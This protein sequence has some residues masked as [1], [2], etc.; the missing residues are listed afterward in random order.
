MKDGLAVDTIYKGQT[1]YGKSAWIYIPKRLL[2]EDISKNY[3]LTGFYDYTHLYQLKNN[4]WEDVAAGGY[5]MKYSDESKIADR[6]SFRLFTDKNDIADAYLV[7]CRRFNNYSPSIMEGKLMTAHQIH[8]WE[9]NINAS[10][11]WLNTI[12]TLLMGMMV[13]SIII[14][15]VRFLL[16]KEIAYLSFM[17]GSVLI[18]LNFFIVYIVEP[19]IIR[20][21]IGNDPLLA[22]AFS[23]ATIISGMGFYILSFK[24]FYKKGDFIRVSNQITNIAFFLCIL[25]SV[26]LIGFEYFFKLF[27]LANIITGAFLF[28]LILSIYGYLIYYKDVF[29]GK[30]IKDSFFII[31]FGSIFIV[32]ASIVGFTLSILFQNNTN[33]IGGAYLLTIPMAV[34]VTIYN[35]ITLTAFTTRDLE[36]ATERD[37]IKRQL[38]ELETQVLQNSLNPH[39]IFNSLNLI[40]YF[41]YK[42][43][44]AKARDTLFKFGDL[45]RN[46]IDRSQDKLISIQDE[47]TLLNLYLSLQKTRK[48]DLFTYHI[49]ISE[50][51][52]KE[53]MHIPVLIT[54]PIV[55]NA[56]K[57]GIMNLENEKDGQIDIDFFIHNNSL[58]ITIRD[59]G[60]GL[61]KSKEL[62]KLNI[63]NDDR[64][65]IGIDLT[66]RR[67][68]LL[69]EDSQITMESPPGGGTLVTIK[70]PII[71]KSLIEKRNN[72]SLNQ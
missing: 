13:L 26:F 63:D 60:I 18:T 31:A 9:Y 59:N 57:H 30:T 68:A 58:F 61:Q 10:K 23:D 25:V 34:G 14:F 21:Y 33:Y 17:I 37:F 11:H 56:L 72:E 40:D 36:V 32:L 45:L 64:K 7:A 65:H 46:V 22:V 67:L 69:S 16:T 52:N 55:E 53:Y 5:Y 6:T 24:H 39:F 41:L 1:T 48:E 70:I 35:I 38:S 66:K 4:Q 15:G 3:I 12:L 20:F 47:V 8:E 43:D 51:V 2:L 29:K 49:Q 19:S 54:Q 27:Y 44:F 62:K 42:K 50:K 71:Y 28:I